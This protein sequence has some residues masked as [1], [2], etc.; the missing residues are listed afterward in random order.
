MAT[1]RILIVDDEP[2]VSA[3]L[4]EVLGRAGYEVITAPS[5]R[6]G[7]LEAVT[8]R[9][10]LVILDDVMPEMDGWATCDHLLSHELTARIPIIFLQAHDTPG[11]RPDDWYRGCLDYIA[12]PC[13]SGELLGRI[14]H[15]FS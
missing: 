2:A 15:V 12:K 14:Q 9:P 4:A 3:Q 6:Q 11:N 10:D 7:V 13:S 1:K 5:G 8:K